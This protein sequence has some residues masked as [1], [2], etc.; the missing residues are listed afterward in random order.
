MS[1]QVHFRVS[2]LAALSCA[3]VATPAASQMA[4][5]ASRPTADSQAQAGLTR[6]FSELLDES[7]P[8]M[9]M[10]PTRAATLADSA[11]AA[12]LVATARAALSRYKDVKLAEQDGYWRNASMVKDQPIYHYNSLHNIKAAAR[13]EFDITKPLSL[14]YK[15]DE[16]G[17][18]RLV[19][20]MYGTGVEN[21]NLD[22]MLPTSMAHW[23]EHVNL[24]SPSREA[25][26]VA[27]QNGIGPATVFVLDLFMNITTAAACEAAGGRF[28]PVDFGWMA[29]VYMFL[30]TDDPRAI[31]DADEVGNVAMHMSH[32]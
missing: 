22:A 18:L 29:H 32:P 20:A 12:A 5:P 7:S 16:H 14:L 24:C 4:Q 6:V 17:Q 26:R 30:G 8:H 25:G 9:R 1:R 13:G 23:H 10:A 11:R 19:G 21:P 27:T 28:E 3:A 31:W 15:N 2:I